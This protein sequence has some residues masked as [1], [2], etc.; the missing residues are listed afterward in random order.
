MPLLTPGE[1]KENT[2]CRLFSPLFASCLHHNGNVLL[3]PPGVK[4][5][6]R[7]HLGELRL[8]LTLKGVYALCDI[9]VAKKMLVSVGA[10]K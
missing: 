7:Q 5:W 6:W 9:T 1:K 4:S 3:Q 2:I 8:T 10:S